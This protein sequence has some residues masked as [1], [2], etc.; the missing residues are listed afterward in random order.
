MI[1][2]FYLLDVKFLTYINSLNLF[3]GTILYVLYFVSTQLRDKET[4]TQKVIFSLISI[5][6]FPSPC[7]TII[8]GPEILPLQL[9][10]FDS[11]NLWGLYQFPTAPVTNYHKSGLLKQHKFILQFWRSHWDKIKVS[12]GLG[13]FLEAYG[14]NLFFCLLQLL[15]ATHMPWLMAAFH[16]QSQQ[17]KA[18]CV[19]HH[20]LSS[21]LFRPLFHF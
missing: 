10:F 7:F 18:K 6:C 5:S 9:H 14:E 17:C 16:L 8:I 1:K 21:S 4:D 13:F 20:H 2:K 19:P 3:S 12:A 11:E 15:E